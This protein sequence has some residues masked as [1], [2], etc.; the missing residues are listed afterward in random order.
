MFVN[1]HVV[2][3]ATSFNIKLISIMNMKGRGATKAENGLNTTIFKTFSAI[4]GEH[5]C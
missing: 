5:R 3:V 4:G 1:G 2:L